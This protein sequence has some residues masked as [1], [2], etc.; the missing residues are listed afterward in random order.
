M[1]ISDL[2][3]KF[4][5]DLIGHWLDI[6]GAALVPAEEDID[7]RQ[8]LSCLDQIAIINL[9]NSPKMTV[10]MAGSVMTRRYGHD[11]RHL[12]WVDLVP[13]VLG[14]IGQRA[15]ERIRK[16][17]CGFYHKVTVG[18]HADA[19]TAE[20]LVLPLRHRRDSVPHAVIGATH[21]QGKPGDNAPAGWL[22]PSAHVAHYIVDLVDI[23]ADISWED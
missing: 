7:P 23:G 21:D 20:A 17:P 3:L 8:L 5:R 1:L 16:L 14:D 9:A 19:V 11:I 12:N 15:R 10:E 6:R 4:A 2:R 13:A 18:S 22:K